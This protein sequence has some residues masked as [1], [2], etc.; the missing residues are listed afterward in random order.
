MGTP[1]SLYIHILI[2]PYLGIFYPHQINEYIDQHPILLI[3]QLGMFSCYSFLGVCPFL[4]KV[5]RK[6]TKILALACI[7]T[8]VATRR[9]YRKSTCFNFSHMCGVDSRCYHTP[10]STIMLHTSPCSCRG[11]R[12]NNTC[13]S[14]EHTCNPS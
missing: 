10:I 2:C 7:D 12:L 14:S 5:V 4:H 13:S 11:V 3:L 6:A 9:H 1:T 8:W